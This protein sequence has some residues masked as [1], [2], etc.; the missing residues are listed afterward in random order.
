MSDNKISTKRQKHLERQAKKLKN[1]YT[2]TERQT[3]IKKCIDELEKVGLYRNYNEDMEKI[4]KTMDEYVE[5]GEPSNGYIPIDGTKRI[6]CFMF[7]RY[8]NNQI[9]TGLKYDENV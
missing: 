4:H 1:Q 8:K 7:P 5:T 9:S 2:K 6:F 3:E